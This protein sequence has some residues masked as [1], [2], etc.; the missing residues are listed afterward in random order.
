[1]LEQASGFDRTRAD[2][3]AYAQP[4]SAGGVGDHIGKAPV[5]RV[6]SSLADEVSVDVPGHFQVERLSGTEGFQL[7]GRPRIGTGLT[8]CALQ[9]ADWAGASAGTHARGSGWR[10][11]RPRHQLP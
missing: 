8:W 6:P 5:D 3:V 4:R 1:M 2:D 10:T 9:G 7:V 11:L